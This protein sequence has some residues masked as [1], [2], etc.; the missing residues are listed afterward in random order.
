MSWTQSND[1][2]RFIAYFQLTPKFVHSGGVLLRP[3]DIT[4]TAQNVL[5][6]MAMEWVNEQQVSTIDRRERAHD[7]AR[8]LGRQMPGQHVLVPYNGAIYAAQL[9]FDAGVGP[10]VITRALSLYWDCFSDMCLTCVMSFFYGILRLP[11]KKSL[12]CRRTSTEQCLSNE[13]RAPRALFATSGSGRV[14]WSTRR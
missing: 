1:T 14:S 3:F 2:L 8:R 10:F 7:V 9:S 11:D 5:R 6:D 12:R 4:R 13:T